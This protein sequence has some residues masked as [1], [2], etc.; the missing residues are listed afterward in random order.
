MFSQQKAPS[1]RFNFPRICFFVECNT[2][3]E[4]FEIDRSLLFYY[5]KEIFNDSQFYGN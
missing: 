4:K 3:I 2:T 5:L 1:P